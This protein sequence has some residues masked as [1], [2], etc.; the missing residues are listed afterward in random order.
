MKEDLLK[1]YHDLG[2]IDMIMIH[3]DLVDRAVPYHSEDAQKIAGFITWLIQLAI[4]K[5]TYLRLLEGTQRHDWKQTA[6]LT[7]IFNSLKTPDVKPNLC[8]YFDGAQI[9][10]IDDL[11]ISVLYLQDEYGDGPEHAWSD[12]QHLLE[13]N[14]LEKVTIGS[15]HGQFAYQLPD[16]VDAPV[17]D[18]K[19]YNS[20][21][22][23]VL[24]CGHVHTRST[25]GLIEVPGSYDVVAHGEEEPKGHLRTRI[26]VDGT[27]TT[28]FIENT[29]KWIYKTIDV[30]G[31]DVYSAVEKL[32]SSVLVDGEPAPPGSCY[33]IFCDQ[34]DSN[35]YKI[36]EITRNW[37]HYNWKVEAPDRVQKKNAESYKDKLNSIY[38][39]TSI[40]PSTVVSL[41][42]NLM[43]EKGHDSDT[44]DKV[45]GVINEFK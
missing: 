33:R 23:C 26:L 31:L 28:T 15:M 37:S 7:E 14:N 38:T 18:V 24:F 34:D 2:H 40:T 5:N 20:I 36:S 13:A 32:R 21:V 27:T 8:K 43:L 25:R 42:N 45:I 6:I 16:H 44:I 1:D 9:E 39:N 17:H 22:E 41:V 19:R 30:R 11:G 12:I 3:G 29:K 35:H 4:H 10:F